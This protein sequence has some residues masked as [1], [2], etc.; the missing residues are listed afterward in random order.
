MEGETVPPSDSHFAALDL[1]ERLLAAG[2]EVEVDREAS[3]VVVS[4]G[5]RL[6]DELAQEIRRRKTDLIELLEPAPPDGPCPD[7][8]SPNYVR[9]RIGPWRCLRCTELTHPERAVAWYYGPSR[10]T[11]EE[12]AR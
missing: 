4:P 2:F 5:S 10:W 1:L 8:G 11:P 7:C 6:T 3:R 9:S 12:E